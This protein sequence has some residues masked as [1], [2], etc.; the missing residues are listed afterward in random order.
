[1]IIKDV[2]SMRLKHRF[3]AAAAVIAM[4]AG[5]IY[6]SKQE[7]KQEAAEET[8]NISWIDNEDTIYFWYTDE[9]MTNFVNSAAVS[10]GER[11][12]VHVIPVLASNSEYLKAL[13]QAS[14]REEQLPDVYMISHDNLEKAYL[15]GLASEI[16]DVGNICT[17]EHFP[18]AALS[19]VEYKGKKVAYPLSFE[20]SALVY[21]VDYLREWS[22][23]TAL[24]ELTQTG[25][26]DDPG[27]NPEEV[28]IDEAALEARA[29][30]VFLRAVPDTVSDILTIA[31]TFDLPEGVEVMKWDVSDIFYNYWIVGNY[32]EVGGDAG[33]DVTRIS[34][35]NPNTISCLEAYQALNQFFFIEANK[36]NY[37]SVMQDF[38]DG[39]I[40]F[41]IATTDVAARL[42]T[43]SEE[44]M[45]GFEYGISM[46]PAVSE[47]LESRSM[48]VTSTIAVNGYSRKKELANRFAAYLVSDCAG[49]LYERT[50]KV[51]TNLSAEADNGALQI[52]KL[53]Y[54]GSVPLPKMKETGNYWLLLERLFAKVW[55]GADV[56]AYVQELNLL[57]TS[58]TSEL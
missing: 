35:N 49:S 23:Q 13:N 28:S 7:M 37:E 48:S 8:S 36:I 1:M 57:I 42:Q 44:G 43:A 52:F 54:A 32:M 58:Q 31:D 11:E 47:E 19:A 56:T 5:V 33:D 29:E 39:K 25:E 15:A 26:D 46:M 14:I 22:R 4:T 9:T 17:A 41:T 45:L 40:V 55:N 53:E 30:E 27:A 16:D 2:E 38:M 34:I 18:A 51:S 20:T 24:N 50:G 10:F 6:G 21:N 3:I 12:K